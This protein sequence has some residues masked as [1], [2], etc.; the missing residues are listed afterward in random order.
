MI[1]AIESTRQK[2]MQYH[3]T[4]KNG[5]VIFCGEVLLEDEKTEKKINYDFVPFKPISSSLYY[6]DKRF[7]T[8][9]LLELLS[10]DKKFGFV[11]V[12]GNGA[13]FATL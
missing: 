6:C 5:L 1:T 7:E 4:P 8:G 12:D 10:D 2:L 9:P 3:E 11:I 13:L